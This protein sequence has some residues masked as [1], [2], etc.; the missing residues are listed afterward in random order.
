MH[1]DDVAI[2]IVCGLEEN[3]LYLNEN[4]RKNPKIKQRWLDREKAFVEYL[5]REK[6][7]A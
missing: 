6:G 1:D 3:I 4:F 5:K 2:C 7:N